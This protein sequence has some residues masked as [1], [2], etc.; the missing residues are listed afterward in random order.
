M[1]NG[2]KRTDLEKIAK[3]M[4]QDV[5][6]MIYEAESGH[7]GGSLGM[8]D[9]FTV[10]YF[11]EVLRLDPKNPNW[12]ERDRLVLSN[13][14]ICPVMY[15]AMAR[16]GFFEREKLW[17]L[18]KMGS[19]LQ[20]H[21]HRET[22]LGLETSSGPLG[23]GLAQA[24]GMALGLRMDGKQN[25]VMVVC[26]DGEHDE[27]N[28]WEAVMMAAKYKLSNLNV[29]VDRNQIQIDGETEE[30]MPL[31]LLKDKYEA[32][33][34]EALEVDGH[35]VGVLKKTFE[36]VKRVER[37][38]AIIAHTI[39]GKGV[40]F[41]EGKFEWHG[42]APSDEEYGQAMEELAKISNIYF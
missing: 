19:E 15:A 7:P 18:R 14:H 36:F 13:G 6:K 27:G 2:S 37:P 21:P 33:G 30:V 24:V 17:S 29:V 42:K 3:E 4:R 12:E 28:H 39:P 40:G 1:S 34:W 8:V 31:K 10:L 38:V 23:S 26:S 25:R 20:G 11:G 35:D 5:V 16:F 41:M 32:F 22:L 9:V